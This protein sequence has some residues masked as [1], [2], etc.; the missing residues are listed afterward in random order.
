MPAELAAEDT[1]DTWRQWMYR[2][3]ATSG[4]HRLSVRATDGTGET[5]PSKEAAPFPNGAT[6][7]HTI[8][9]NVA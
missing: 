7:N 4:D 6:G 8:A 2:W 1:L 5:Q 3:N 9:V